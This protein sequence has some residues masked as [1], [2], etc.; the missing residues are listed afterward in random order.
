MSV[1]SDFL[2]AHRT[3]FRSVSIISFCQPVPETERSFRSYVR[4]YKTF[5]LMSTLFE[6]L[7]RTNFRKICLLFENVCAI[8]FL[9]K[10]INKFSEI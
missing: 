5:V 2:P 9:R 10:L 3:L 8:L 6:Q 4:L 1:K 7:F